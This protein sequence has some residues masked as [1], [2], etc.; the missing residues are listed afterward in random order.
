MPMY[1]YLCKKHGVFE[2]YHPYMDDGPED[3]P[4]CKA[5]C[6]RVAHKEQRLKNPG[7]VRPP[8]A[9]K[10]WGEKGLVPHRPARWV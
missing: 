1:D 9:K 3:C 8:L 5:L 10:K 4:E 6:P 2:S 7:Y